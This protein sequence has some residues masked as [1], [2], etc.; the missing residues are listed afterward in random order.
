M[1]NNENQ[2]TLKSPIQNNINNI[3]TPNKEF[4]M[5]TPKIKNEL[6]KLIP[7]SPF[8]NKNNSPQ[9]KSYSYINGMNLKN[10]SPFIL[11]SSFGP[12]S[13]MN[14]NNNNNNNFLETSNNFNKLD[15]NLNYKIVQKNLMD[16]FSPY[17][18]KILFNNN[19]YKNET[20]ERDTYSKGKEMYPFLNCTNLSKKFNALA[21]Q[22]IKEKNLDFSFNEKEKEINKEENSE[23][24]NNNNNNYSFLNGFDNN[25]FKNEKFFYY[26][27]NNYKSGI[28]LEEINTDIENIKNIF[29]STKNKKKLISHTLQTLNY[30]LIEKFSFDSY[31][32]KKTNNNENKNYK[33][34]TTSKKKTKSSSQKKKNFNLHST[35]T[36]TIRSISTKEEFFPCKCKHSK[37]LKLYCECFANGLL[38]KNCNC[39]DCLN[40]NENEELRKKTYL[41]VI[42][43][44][45]KAIQ[46]IKRNKKSWNC[47][48]KN[49][50]C[51]KNY[52]DC[53]QNGKFCSSKCKCIDCLN[54]NLNQNKNKKNVNKKKNEE[55][56]YLKTP[57]KK[58]YREN[59]YE[60]KNNFSTEA[61]TELYNSI[62]QTS[63]NKK[64]FLS[65]KK[66]FC[67]KLNLD[68]I[69]KD[70][71]INDENIIN[72]NENEKFFINESNKKRKIK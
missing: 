42:Q 57:I 59:N 44:N 55:L 62:D 43:K 25:N 11:N 29:H 72:N 32:N 8:V 50:N 48:C 30:N 49:S 45:P 16:E 28:I 7:I 33:F 38:C 9:E 68:L 66:N 63:I 60:I 2:F 53:F 22:I 46:K 58:N 15:S 54:K 52:C 12:F 13:P 23:I 69:V 17:K 37:C 35:N 56:D 21:E 5:G 4:T 51:Q 3:S 65:N 71:K 6:F 18:P 47:R 67:K 24:S 64:K 14:N 20:F 61:Y 34:L 1:E 31:N 41:E 26:N 70:K 27:Q 19:S 36:K 40:T 39:I 10:N